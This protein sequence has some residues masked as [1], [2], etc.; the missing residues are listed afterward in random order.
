V[1]DLRLRGVAGR[2]GL[3]IAKPST[4]QLWVRARE[5]KR[6]EREILRRKVLEDVDLAL[7]SLIDKYSWAEC[8]LF[9]S[10]IAPGRFNPDS[11]VDI[12]VGGLAKQDLYRFVGEI[13]SALERD[14]DVVVLEESRLAPSIRRK[15]IPWFPKRP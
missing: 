3:G 15:G 1:A 11:D 14:V 10:V 12:A 7:S 8:Y 2:L 4:P 13:S 6:R 5:R 9:G